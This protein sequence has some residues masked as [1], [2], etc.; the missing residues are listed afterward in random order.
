MQRRIYFP[1][2]LFLNSRG[3]YHLRRLGGVFLLLL[4]F[5]S[6]GGGSALA[7]TNATVGVQITFN[8]HATGPVLPETAFGVNA[9]SDWP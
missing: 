1:R 2:F 8:R 6:F 9:A 5:F 3:H 4:G 7:A